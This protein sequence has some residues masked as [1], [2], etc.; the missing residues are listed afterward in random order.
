[1]QEATIASS[2]DISESTTKTASFEV[3]RAVDLVKRYGQRTVV[4]QVSIEVHPGEVVGLLGP[5]GAGKTTS[6]YMM[7]GLIHPNSGKVYLGERE[8][9]HHAMYRRARLGLGY[10]PQESS[11]FR[12]LTVEQNMHAILEMRGMKFKERKPRVERLLEEFRLT[13]RRSVAGGLLSGGERRRTEIARTLACEP[14]YILLDEPFT[15]IDPIAVEEIQ[16]IVRTLRDKGI[17]VL[18]TDHNVLDTLAITERVY[19]IYEGQIM[20]HGTPD[21]IANDP[22]A[23]KYYL[24][25][26]FSR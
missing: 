9:T 26:R 6:F 24:S 19:I 8:I 1:M 22:M 16:A 7:V 21:E 23:R 20:T 12:R 17:G 25:E 14:S 4:N 10:L 2:S 13:D 15:G 5:N 18:I 3:L 11:I